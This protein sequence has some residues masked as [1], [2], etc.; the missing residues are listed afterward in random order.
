MSAVNFETPFGRAEAMQQ[1]R[2]MTREDL[3][4]SVETVCA[5]L[6]SVFPGIES[7]SEVREAVE[8]LAREKQRRDVLDT[9]AQTEVPFGRLRVAGR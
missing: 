4:H 1:A 2:G 6:A 5:A 8:V 3:D 9:I 7:L